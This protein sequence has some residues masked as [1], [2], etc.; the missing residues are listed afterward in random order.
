MAGKRALEEKLAALHALRANPTTDAAIAALR[1]ALAES[2]IEEA[3]G[4]LVAVWEEVLDP[5]FRRTVLV[6]IALLRHEE[7]IAFLLSLLADGSP[8]AAHAAVEALGMY[9]QD[10]KVWRRV[11]QLV[12]EREDVEL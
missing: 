8:A 6:A 1:Q 3:F 7:A 9:R 5:D 2:R 4:F 11:R 10:D 12:D